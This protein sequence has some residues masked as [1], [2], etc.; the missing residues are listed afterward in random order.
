MLCLSVSDQLKTTAY[1][2][3]VTPRSINSDRPVVV[4]CDRPIR[5]LLER[6][7]KQQQKLTPHQQ[8]V[9]IYRTAASNIGTEYVCFRLYDVWTRR[10][11]RIGYSDIQHRLCSIATADSSLSLRPVV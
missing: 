8:R 4:E 2:D 5:V 1:T 11:A 10:S 9:T 7:K 6:D 3:V